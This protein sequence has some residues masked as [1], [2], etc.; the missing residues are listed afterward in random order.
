MGL[1][2]G[3]SEEDSPP[4]LVKTGSAKS[5]GQGSHLGVHEVGDRH[6]AF[7]LV[8]LDSEKVG[9]VLQV[10]LEGGKVQRHLLQL[11]TDRRSRSRLCNANRPYEH[12]SD[13][14]RL[15]F[16]RFGLDP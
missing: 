6:R 7:L 8:G 14:C 13:E 3:N 16:H 1:I 12:Q 4:L 11:Q 9:F 5:S 2:I 15:H 10:A